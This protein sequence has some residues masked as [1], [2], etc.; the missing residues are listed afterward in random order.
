MCQ[1]DDFYF[2][3]IS[4]VDQSIY[5]LSFWPPIEIVLDIE[6]SC[7]MGGLSFLAINC[8]ERALKCAQRILIEEV[9]FWH[10]TCDC[11]PLFDTLQNKLF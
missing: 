8:F 2:I 11:I 6:S 4:G 1:N 5:S 10:H 7:K 3:F 9:L